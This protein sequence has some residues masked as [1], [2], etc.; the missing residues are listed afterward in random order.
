MH[1]RGPQSEPTAVIMFN[2]HQHQLEMQLLFMT[3]VFVDFFNCLPHSADKEVEAQDS[4]MYLIPCS[5]SNKNHGRH[6]EHAC[7]VCS[8]S[9][10][11][12]SQPC[13]GGDI[14]SISQTGKLRL[15]LER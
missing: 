12:F 5:A 7:C 8:P 13:E 14:A 11:V 1:E 15:S 10:L 9:C 6:G 4:F 2:L 3:L